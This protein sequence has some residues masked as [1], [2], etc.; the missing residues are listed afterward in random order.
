M[1]LEILWSLERLAAELT[2]VRLQWHMN[3]DVRCDVIPLNRRC[4]ALVPLAG[5]VQVVG[6]LATNMALTEVV[7]SQSQK[8]SGALI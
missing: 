5:Q 2:L 6:A 8:S 1:L 4:P 7:L 3:T